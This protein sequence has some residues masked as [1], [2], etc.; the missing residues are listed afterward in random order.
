MAQLGKNP[1]AMRETCV[2]PGLG[3][4]PGEGISY[5]SVTF[6]NLITA[7]QGRYHSFLF[8]DVD[9]R[10]QKGLAVCHTASVWERLDSNLLLFTF[11]T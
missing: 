8:K 6:F 1:P 9:I 2:L 7:L 11:S 3:R 4:S 5:Y 10:N